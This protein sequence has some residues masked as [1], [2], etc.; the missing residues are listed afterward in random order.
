VLLVGLN[1]DEFNLKSLFNLP[2]LKGR[3]PKILF[4][5]NF[6][7]DVVFISKENGWPYQFFLGF[8]G[9]KFSKYDKV[10]IFPIF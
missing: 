5:A 7:A 1:G 9:E 4:R 2:K 3:M 6:L 10:F 8:R